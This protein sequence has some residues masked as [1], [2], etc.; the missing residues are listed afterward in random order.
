MDETLAGEAM[1]LEEK[2][3]DGQEQLEAEV[4]GQDPQFQQLVERNLIC[5][6]RKMS[7]AGFLILALETG[8]ACFKIN[9]AR[10][11]I[12]LSEIGSTDDW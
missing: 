3:V 4:T 12:I 5:S 11:P 1:L 9:L 8:L 10:A 7:E 6:E 2:E